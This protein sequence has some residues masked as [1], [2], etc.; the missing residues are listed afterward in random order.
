[1]NRTIKDWK[2]LTEREIGAVTGNACSF[3]KR[4][5][6]VITSAAK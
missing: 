2:K 6:K 3:R 5:G 1:V 4:V